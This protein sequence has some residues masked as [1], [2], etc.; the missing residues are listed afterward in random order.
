MVFIIKNEVGLTLQ[1]ICIIM[2][3]KFTYVTSLEIIKMMKFTNCLFIKIIVFLLSGTQICAYQNQ[4][5]FCTPGIN[6]T[7]I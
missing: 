1:L 5:G 2:L 4:A 3:I 6:F 7:W